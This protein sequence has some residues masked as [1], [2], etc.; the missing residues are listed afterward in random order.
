MLKEHVLGKEE[1]GGRR[2]GVNEGE[3]EKKSYEVGPGKPLHVYNVCCGSLKTAHFLT[4]ALQA[5]DVVFC[6]LS[7][8]SMRKL[9]EKY[10]YISH[11]CSNL[12]KVESSSTHLLCMCGAMCLTAS[13]RHA[14]ASREGGTFMN[15]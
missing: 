1:R 7:L 10:L 8:S 6:L 13:H 15:W 3:R 11:T 14:L 4:S 2:D 5:E 9:R 12:A